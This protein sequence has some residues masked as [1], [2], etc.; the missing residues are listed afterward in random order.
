MVAVVTAFVFPGL[1]GAGHFDEH[2]PLLQLPGFAA[3]WRLVATTFGAAP[4]FAAFDR[5]LH[6]G[7]ELSGAPATWPWRALSVIAMQ[8][9]AA[10]AL[11]QRGERADWLCGYSIGDLARSCHAGAATFA[12][13]VAFAA[14]LPELPRAAGGTL[15]VLP[16]D[17]ACGDALYS[18]LTA[19][20][21]AVCRL[22]PRFLLAAGD[23]PALAR[24]RD[25]CGCAT[26]RTR[27]L[28]ACPLHTPV[29]GPLVRVLAAATR[30]VR[31]SPPQRRMFSTLWGR[32]I[33]GGDDLCAE[34]T[35]NVAAPID[36]AGAV[37]R[38]RQQHGV[39]RFIDLGPGRHAQRFV[40]HHGDDVQA[41]HGAELLAS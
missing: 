20:G 35:T 29:Q 6:D 27:D 21:V 39:T 3:R 24:A 36:F 40:R 12:Q 4:G 17:A 10:E 26:V 34:F 16:P 8:L 32:A 37:Q 38:L 7:S 15:A 28:G 31:L 23:D 13:V 25:I 22:S 9:A 18:E 5:A 41:V 33:A 19:A 11:E 1:N 14:A 2:A 30:G